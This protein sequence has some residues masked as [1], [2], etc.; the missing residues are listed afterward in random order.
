[1]ASWQSVTDPIISP[2]I[3]GLLPEDEWG[4]WVPNIARKRRLMRDYAERKVPT[5][6]VQCHQCEKFADV[7]LR[8]LSAICP[9]CH[10]HLQMG[11]F[12]LKSGMRRNKLRTQGDVVIH[13]DANLSRLNL[14]C[15]NLVMKGVGDGYINCRGKLTVYSKPHMHQSVKAGHLD[16]RLFSELRLENGIHV[17]KADIRGELR[18]F[19]HATG[20]VRIRRGGV[21]IGDCRAL[22]LQIDSG[23]RH[24][25]HFEQ[26]H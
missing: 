8:A 14:V 19:I 24:I 6:R 4:N 12:V 2:E 10:T 17:E 16:M 9:F 3:S 23:G 26:I 15:T 21:L 25:G 13:A 18:G 1:M 20:V 11:D 22:V 5:R 7:P